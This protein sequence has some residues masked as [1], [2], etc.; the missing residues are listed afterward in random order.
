MGVCEEMTVGQWVI[1][2][3]VIVHLGNRVDHPRLHCA[4]NVLFVCGALSAGQL[5]GSDMIVMVVHSVVDI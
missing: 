3:E 4:V 1:D 2:Q 5:E